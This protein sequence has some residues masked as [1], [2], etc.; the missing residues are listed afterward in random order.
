MGNENILPTIEVGSNILF[1]YSRIL[2]HPTMGPP[3]IMANSNLLGGKIL[4]FGGGNMMGCDNMFGGGKTFVGRNM[5]G[6]YNIL[7]GGNIMG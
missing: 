2:G 1:S 5:I 4:M 7:N 6:A 3:R